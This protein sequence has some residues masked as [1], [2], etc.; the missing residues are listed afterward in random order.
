MKE[1]VGCVVGVSAAFLLGIGFV[2]HVD[3]SF[4]CGTLIHVCWAFILVYKATCIAWQ[5]NM[6]GVGLMLIPMQA[7]HAWSSCRQDHAESLVNNNYNN[8]DNKNN[9]IT[10]KVYAVTTGWCWSSLKASLLDVEPAVCSIHLAHC[11]CQ[12]QQADECK[13][14]KAK[15]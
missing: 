15:L 4:V 9:K 10:L 7:A 11:C 1:L 8:K 6:V 2:L 12:E 3:G 13:T 5:K 14:A